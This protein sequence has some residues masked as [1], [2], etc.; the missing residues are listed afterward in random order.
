[1]VICGERSE[2]HVSQGRG[3][4]GFPYLAFFYNEKKELQCEC[5]SFPHYSSLY[6]SR[7]LCA[8]H[9]CL[10]PAHPVLDYDDAKDECVCRSHPC[11]N[12]KGRSHKCDKPQFPILKFR[13]EEALMC[14]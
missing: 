10:D 1:M 11:W 2:G 7:D 5:S 14:G 4:S 13:H 12:D 9:R 3:Q 6:I 8:G